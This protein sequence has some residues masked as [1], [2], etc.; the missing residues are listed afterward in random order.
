MSEQDAAGEILARCRVVAMVGLSNKPDR[1][2]YR[3]ARYLQSHGY[4]VIPVNPGLTEV[5]GEKS[6]P[7]LASVPGQVDV[8]DIFRRSEDV[9]PIVDAAIARGIKAV[10]MQEGVVSEAAAERARAAGLLVVMDH[11]MMKEHKKRHP[12]AP[13]SAAAR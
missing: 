12:R 13:E 11:C 5:L 1:P 8:V 9:P 3:V 10:W 6:Y 2:S 4:R 7:D